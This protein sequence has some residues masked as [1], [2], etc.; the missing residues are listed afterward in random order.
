MRNAFQTRILAVALA[1]ATL[2]VCVLAGFNLSQELKAEFP[3]D[4]IVWVEAQGG[5][6]AERVPADS[7]GARAGI[8]A[9]DILQAIDD[10]PTP[11]VAPLERE[12]D[13]S[14]VWSHA[15]YSILRPVAAT[16]GA[17]P[18]AKLD[19]Q[20]I[21]ESA[22]RSTDQG[23]RLIAV[24]Y[25]LIGLYVLFRRWTAPK[26]THFYVFCLVS[27][28]LYAFRSTGEPGLFD[29][30]IYWCNLIATMLQPALFLH[31]AISFSDV[32]GVD[33]GAEKMVPPMLRRGLLAV[34][35]YVPGA[36]LAGLQVWAIRYWSA[37]GVLSHRLDQIHYGYMALYYVIAAV[38]FYSRYVRAESGLERQQQIGRASCR[39]RV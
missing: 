39:E 5:L 4:G 37:T 36:F 15:T 26:A 20:L 12:M 23:S 35:L 21:L 22:D 2:G 8:R 38:V 11:R 19:I 17:Q 24:V 3:T 16:R 34:L 27:F 29:R 1:L 14:G 7:P 13:R 28:V 30:V 32:S 10:V 31:F 33:E 18:G 25:I 6:R 9:G